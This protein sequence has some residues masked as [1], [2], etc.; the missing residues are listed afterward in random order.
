MWSQYGENH[1]GVCLAFSREKLFKLIQEKYKYDEY[2][3][4]EGEVEYK[5]YV[6][7]HSWHDSVTVDCDTFDNM[8]P[9]DVAIEH[10][11]KFQ[12]EL[13]FR[14]QLDYKDENEFRVVAMYKKESTSVFEVPEFEV[15]K[16]LL[17]IILGDRFP[18]AYIPSITKLSNKL[19]IKYRRLHWESGEYH[20][21]SGN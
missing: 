16:C 10:I 19:N 17:G 3:L 7:D 18:K 1:E 13:L 14:K 20:L 2:L 9:F 6:N 12:R 4:Y 5:D 11:S 8:T 21:L 15:S